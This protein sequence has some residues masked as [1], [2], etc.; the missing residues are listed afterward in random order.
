MTVP[1]AVRVNVDKNVQR[2]LDS[3]VTIRSTEKIDYTTFGELVRSSG[4]I[5]QP[6]TTLS[7]ATRRS[8]RS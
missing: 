4:T 1:E 6:S 3:G 7:A 8:E 2:E 5:G